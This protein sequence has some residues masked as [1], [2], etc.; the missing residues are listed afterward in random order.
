MNR[1]CPWLGCIW[2]VIRRFYV[3]DRCLCSVPTDPHHFLGAGLFQVLGLQNRQ[4]I[5]RCRHPFASSHAAWRKCPRTHGADKLKGRRV[6]LIAGV[7]YL[8]GRK[9]GVHYQIW[10]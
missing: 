4:P 8:H 9:A 2:G 3:H 10:A 6:S 7:E 5:A 1:R